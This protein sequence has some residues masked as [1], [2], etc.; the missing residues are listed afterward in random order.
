VSEFV[1]LGQYTTLLSGRRAVPR[2]EILKRLEISPAT[3]KRDLAKLRD[4]MQVP[5]RFDADRGGYFIE[6][7]DGAN[8]ALPGLWFSPDEILALLTLQHLLSQLEPGLLGPKLKPLQTRLAALMKLHGLDS[9]DVAHRMRIVHAGK[10]ALPPP[11]FEAV[12]GATMARKRLTITHM[13]RE[14]GETLQRDISPQRMVHYRD[15]WYVDAWCHLRDDLR[16]FSLDAISHVE[17]QDD[18]AKEVPP[19]EIDQKLGAGYGIFGGKPKA[20][21]TLRFTPHRARW[22]KGEQWH[23]MQES[24]EEADGSYVLSV[25]YSDDREIVGDILRFGADV[26]VLQ[27]HELRMKVQKM[28]L[29]AAS[30][31]V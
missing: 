22:V 9:Q 2:G 26:Q 16:S 30:A 18:A 3:F 5:I 19:A 24:H 29:N 13:R 11:L 23:P 6:Q 17:H 25:P 7:G 1:R 20:W 10:R 31:Y 8:N 28:F 27:P 14:T 15:N 21:A 4:Q 12:A